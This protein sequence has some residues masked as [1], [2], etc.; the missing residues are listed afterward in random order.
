MFKQF[1]II[2]FISS[3]I[4]NYGF[5]FNYLFKSKNSLKE[6]ENVIEN[7]NI[8]EI[9]EIYQTITTANK[10]YLEIIQKSTKL[11]LLGIAL[12]ALEFDFFLVLLN[13]KRIPY[14]IKYDGF[15]SGVWTLGIKKQLKIA[16]FLKDKYQIIL[17]IL[18]RYLENDYFTI[19]SF[20]TERTTCLSKVVLFSFIGSTTPYLIA[21]TAS[22][23]FPFVMSFFGMVSPGIGTFHAPLNK[24][25]TAAILKN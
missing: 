1:L 21:K 25:G 11:N 23:F 5:N 12:N 20:D 14:Q 24:L 22:T 15:K 4:Y 17:D 7:G 6:W 19:S 8:N 13:D 9:K 18:K 3:F 2:W 10:K 16:S